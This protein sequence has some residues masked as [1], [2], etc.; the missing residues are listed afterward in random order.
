MKFRDITNN[1]HIYSFHPPPT[2]T[3]RIAKA[4]K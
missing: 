1:S 2:P 3:A 4:G